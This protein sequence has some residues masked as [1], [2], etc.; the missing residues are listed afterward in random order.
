MAAYRVL[1]IVFR[2]LA[3]R[4]RC[5]MT[6]PSVMVTFWMLGFHWRLVF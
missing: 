1:F 3:Q 5:L 4:F 2:H 6:L